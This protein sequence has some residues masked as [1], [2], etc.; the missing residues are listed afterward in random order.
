MIHRLYE[1]YRKENAKNLI[2]EETIT[3]QDDSKKPVKKSKSGVVIEGVGDVAVRFPN[4]AIQY[5][6]M[7]L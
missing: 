6:V 1:E 3:I 5:L 2:K 7:K 4:A